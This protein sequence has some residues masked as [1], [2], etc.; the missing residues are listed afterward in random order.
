MWHSTVPQRV[1]KGA[2]ATAAATTAA[3]EVKEEPDDSALRPTQAELPLVNALTQKGVPKDDALL[4]LRQHGHNVQEALQHALQTLCDRENSRREDMARYESEKDKEK[5]ATE[6]RQEDMTLTVLGDVAPRFQE[7][8]HT[9]P[10]A[11]VSGPVDFNKHL[12]HLNALY[13][14]S[15]FCHYP[16]RWHSH[17]HQGIGLT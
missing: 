3:E 2:A 5:I 14:M 17:H 12:K 11:L 4:S 7:V 8:C 13:V 1:Q 6:R 15:V 16:F 10:V 9:S